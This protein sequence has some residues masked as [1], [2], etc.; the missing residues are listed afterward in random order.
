MNAWMRRD[1]EAPTRH[2][3]TGDD[4]L[5]MMA[6]GVLY[7]G[8]RFELIDGE[9]IDMPAEG[10]LHLSLKISLNRFLIR[11]LPDEIALTPDGTLRLSESN[12]PEPDFYL[13]PAAMRVSQVRGPDLLLVIEI[14]DSTLAHD[15]RR[16]A[17]LYRRFGVREYWVADV[18]AGV[19]HV[20]RLDG[21]WP[22]PPAPFEAELAPSLI[23]GLRL[24]IADF[25]PPG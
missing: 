22:A 15:L 11:A 18:N 14:S 17:E 5:R 7:E 10:D 6:A 23:P 8:G 21:A 16:K 20:H 24:R 2:G 1:L 13:F 12:W 4:V 25:L 3:F 19:T 9:I